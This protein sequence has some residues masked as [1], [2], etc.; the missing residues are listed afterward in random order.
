MESLV[1]SQKFPFS[2]KA[3][4]YLKEMGIRIEDVLERQVKKSALLVSRANSGQDY[5]LDINSPSKEMLETEI[6]SF[7]VAKM[8]VSSIN[9][10]NIIEKFCDLFRKKTFNEILNEK[11][12]IDV[13]LLL[14]DDFKIKYDL[15][16]EDYYKIPLLQYIDIYFIDNESKLINKRV[17][18]GFVFL[19]NNDFARFLS[20]KTYQKIFDSL[21]IKKDLIPKKIVLL[22]KNI[23]SQLATIQ[24][25]NYTSQVMGKIKIELF[26]PSMLALYNKQLAGEKLSYYERLTIGGFLQQIGMQKNEMLIFFSKSPDYKKNIAEYHVNRIYE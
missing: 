12:V 5:L 3:R 1:F 22:S 4:D 6:I 13:M 7:P 19:N 24:Q 20:E 15:I 21:P 16:E 17:E 9:T 25:K 2:E 14:A 26:P 18:N 8:I 23:S 11:K 10:P